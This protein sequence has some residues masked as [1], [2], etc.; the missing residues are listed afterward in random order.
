MPKCGQCGYI[1][2]GVAGV[3]CPECGA[4][5][6]EVGIVTG[7]SGPSDI[8]RC[9]CAINLPTSDEARDLPVD[10]GRTPRCRNRLR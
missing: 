2:R 3:H 9:F 10:R 5:L 7:K 6:R 8:S 1:V 4:D